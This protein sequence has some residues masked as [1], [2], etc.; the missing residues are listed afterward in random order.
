M[1][2]QKPSEGLTISGYR[3]KFIRDWSETIAKAGGIDLK[4]SVKRAYV[5][6]CV[7]QIMDS[8]IWHSDKLNMNFDDGYVL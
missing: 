8:A 2:K 5:E 1:K 7:S 4:D 6:L 3:Q